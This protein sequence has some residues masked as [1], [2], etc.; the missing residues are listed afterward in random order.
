[1]AGIYV[2]RSLSVA[3]SERQSDKGLDLHAPFLE[4]RPMT[5]LLS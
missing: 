4:C 2:K 3:A 1:M 5:W